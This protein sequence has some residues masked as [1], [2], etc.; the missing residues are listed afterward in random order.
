MGSFAV[1]PQQ[2]WSQGDAAIVNA[3]TGAMRSARD[4]IVSIGGDLLGLVESYVALE[5]ANEHEK[6]GNGSKCRSAE[7]MQVSA[8]VLPWAPSSLS[9]RPGAAGVTAGV[10]VVR[11]KLPERL[12]QPVR[13]SNTASQP[14]TPSPRRPPF[15]PTSPIATV[16]NFY[17][18]ATSMDTL[19]ARYSRP[20]FENETLAEEQQAAQDLAPPLSLNFALPPIAST[21]SWLRAMTDDHSNPNVPIKIAH[22]TTTLAFRFKGGIIVATDSRASA[23]NWIASQTVKKVIEINTHLLG[24]MAGGAAVGLA[25]AGRDLMG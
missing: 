13:T 9:L 7:A 23:G 21:A 3:R 18:L 19:V 12:Q 11:V 20:A 15:H 25:K 22:G 16:S 17:R 1:P 6:T 24:T 4:T 2:A 8:R 14:P 10:P 5:T